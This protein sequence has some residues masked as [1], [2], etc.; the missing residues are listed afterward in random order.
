MYIIISGYL[1]PI[2]ALMVEKYLRGEISCALTK[3]LARCLVMLT[4]VVIPFV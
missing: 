2:R 1:D 4:P 3:V